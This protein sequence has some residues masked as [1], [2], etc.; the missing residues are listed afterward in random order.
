ML[1]DVRERV[2]QDRL[3]CAI[4]EQTATL[5]SQPAPSTA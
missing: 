1:L 4:I 2:A 3:R 5:P